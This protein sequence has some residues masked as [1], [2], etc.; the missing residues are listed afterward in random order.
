MRSAVQCLHPQL[1]FP[2]KSFLTFIL[3]INANNRKFQTEQDEPMKKLK[4]CSLPE[5]GTNLK[6][7]LVA[8]LS[9]EAVVDYVVIHGN[10]V[11]D[12]TVETL[13]RVAKSKLVLSSTIE[14][15]LDVLA[16]L[17]RLESVSDLHTVPHFN[18]KLVFID[19]L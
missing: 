2:G 10:D 9:P 6:F 12:L 3:E 17:C 5:L 18:G 1:V 4:Q 8:E 14:K 11:T 13:V 15:L 19:K 7:K 16:E